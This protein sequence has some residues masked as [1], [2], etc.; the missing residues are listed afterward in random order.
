MKAFAVATNIKPLQLKLIEVEKPLPTEGEV[1][2]QINAAGI[3]PSELQWHPTLHKADGSPRTL[4]IPGHEFSGIVAEVG[5]GVTRFRAGDA[6]FGM[7][8]WYARGATA[9]F[10]LASED[11]IIVKPAGLSDAVAAALPISG[12]TAW[13]AINTR[14][15]AKTGEHVLIV[16]AAGSVGL[17]AVQ[18]AVA[19]G[20]RVTAVANARHESLLKE[21]GCSDVIDYRATPFEEAT[22]DIDILLD[23]VGADTL[24]RATPLLTA[25]GRLITIAA[26]AEAKERRLFSEAFF[27]VESSAS[28]LSHLAK[29]VTE[30]KLRVFVRETLPFELAGKAY[31][32]EIPADDKLGKLVCTRT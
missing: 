3:T 18:I 8:D 30:G 15:R 2:V 27:I 31:M 22:S 16:G 25:K 7:N 10:C 9:E 11:T 13:Q 19:Q 21:L 32:N 12:L 29:L 14:A 24:E 1:L 17:M 23:T 20:C 28:E 4:A 5:A 26:D 6:V